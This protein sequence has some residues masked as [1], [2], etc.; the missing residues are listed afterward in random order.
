MATSEFVHLH[1]H[2]EYSLLDG[3]C[4]INAMAPAAAEQGMSALAVTDHGNLFGAISHYRACHDAGVKPILGC[5]TYVSIG[6][7]HERKG[8]RGLTHGSNHLVL[9]A[10]NHQGWKNL[11]KLVSKG[12]TEGFYYNPRIDKELLR[13]YSEGLVCLS[14]CVSGEVAHLIREEGLDS[15]ETAAREFMDIFGDDY[16]LE[17]Q[18]HGIDIEAKVNDGL[19][20]LHDRLDVPL[21]A[22]ND[23]HF[24]GADDHSAHD[25]LVCIQT[26]KMIADTQRMCYPAGLYMK[27][28]AE[29]QKLF[30]D[31]PQAIENTVAIAEKCNV[32]LQ[33]GDLILPEF[34]IPDEFEHAY[35]YLTHLAHDGLKRRY[36]RTDDAL[37]DRVD[38]ELGI[39]KQM[40][41]VDYFLIVWDYVHYAHSIGMTVG[42]GRGSGAG[43]LVAYSLGITNTDPIKHSLLFE[44]FLNPE[45]VSPPDFDIDFADREKLVQYVVEKYGE[46]NVCQI[47]TFGTM[48][49][50]AVL[51]DVGRVLGMGFGDVDAIAKLV[52]NELKI[53]LDSAIEKTPELKMMA[54][55]KGD[56]QQQQLLTH[57]LKLEGLARHAS[58]HAAGVIIAPS[59]VSDYMPLYRAPKDGKITTQWDGPTCEDFGFL[60]MDFLGLNELNLMDEAVRLIRLQQPEFDIDALP[61]DDGPT[62]DLFGR[63]ETVG[64]FQ[65]ESAGMREYL[66]QLKPDKIADIIA[67]NALYR[68]GPMDKIPDYI[69]RKQ[70]RQEVVYLH[71][72]LEEILAETY[73]VIVY[74]EQVLQIAQKMAGFTLGGAD[75]LRRAM[76]KKKAEEMAKQKKAFIDGCRARDVDKSVAETLFAEIDV[77]SG[78]GF[79]KCHAAPYAELAYKNAYLKA[80]WPGEYMAASMTTSI[81]DSDK[82]TVL[83]DE[84]RRM[85]IPVLPPNV[86]ESAPNFTPTPDGV[87]FGLAAIKNVGQG[88]AQ[89]IVDGRVQD[90]PYED[91]FKFCERL[92]LRAVNRRVV[93]SLTAAGGLD[94]FGGGHRAQMLEVLDLALRHAQTV[95]EERGRGQFSLFGGDSSAPEIEQQL[96]FPQVEPWTETEQLAYERDLL[97]FYVTSHPLSRFERD[98]RMF[99]TPLSEASSGND[100][101]AIRV[102]GL[103]TRISTSSDRRGNTIAFVTIEDL[104]GTT[105]IVFFADAYEASRDLLVNDRVILVEGRLNERKGMMSILVDTAIGLEEARERLTRAVNVALPANHMCEEL[106]SD[107][108]SVCQQF[109]GRCDLVIH[110]QGVDEMERDTLIRSRS[111][112]VNPCDELLSSVDALD[113]SPETWLTAVPPHARLAR[114]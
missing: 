60:K 63:G 8:A 103:I 51:R 42:P 12:Y 62:Y 46:S 44:R 16:Y 14:A 76:G 41:F 36:D 97:G 98:L 24:L 48:G 81:G 50:K 113:G 74:Q 71:P 30:A 20:K 9:L 49:A 90:G 104:K 59:D 53:T 84:C 25:A 61:W 96:T 67:M 108:R 85:E 101:E 83:L 70:G 35:D 73:G 26:G 112:R 45:R 78:Y 31:L 7:R 33:F 77:F 79:N 23:F 64:V 88:A 99:A 2:S 29:M 95:Q 4:H 17:I 75:I 57:A 65:F 39:I 54:Q 56:A 55:G 102:G 21:V 89:S 110:L 91:L 92:D 5:E 38:Y 10:K 68:P 28:P 6:S 94:E 100:G 11:I 66:S 15:A 72:D 27:S 13:E 86:N 87:R 106:L 18:R 82:V 22:T 1:G 114:A 111:I 105:D 19:L 93:E 107:L 109:T 32:E 37:R 40:G 34:T 47:I 80:N 52:P 3:A 43:S 69:A 58:I